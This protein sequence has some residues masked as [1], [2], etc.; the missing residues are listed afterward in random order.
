MSTLSWNC[1]GLG[2]P[3]A[4]EFL[5]DICFQKKPKFLFLCETLCTKELVDRVRVRLGFEGAFSVDVNGRKGGLSMFWRLNDE[6]KMLG[7]S[8][9]HIDLEVSIQDFNNIASNDEKK[10]VR[11]YPSALISGFQSARDDCHL[12]DLELRG[13]PFTWE[14]GKG[15]DHCIEIRLDKAN[16]THDWLDIFNHSTLTNIGYTCSDHAPIFLQP[17]TISQAAPFHCFRYKNVWSCEPICSQLVEDCWA[18]SQGIPISNNYFEL[19][20]QQEIYWKQRSK[21]FWLHYGDKNTKYFHAS[22][23]ARKRNNQIRQPQNSDGVWTDWEDG[24][25]QVIVNYFINLYTTSCSTNALVISE[26]NCTVSGSQNE[27]LL[28]P[29]SCEEVKLALFQIHPDKAPGPDGSFPKELNETNLVLIPK[30]KNVAT[31]GDLRPIA[32]CNVIYKLISK[33]LANRM[34]SIIDL[35]ISDTQSAFIPGRLISDNI[36]VAFEVMHYLKRKTKGK[37]GYMALKLD[38]SKDYDRVEWSYIHAVMLQMGFDEQWVK[39]IMFCVSSVSYSVMRD[40]HGMGPI[41]PSRGIRQGDPLSTYL[42]IICADGFSALI[43]KF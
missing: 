27:E 33:V 14:H 26:I 5:E 43:K 4:I 28:K 41:L 40:G 19:L 29:V 1:R 35:I 36:M 39:L 25:D 11:P 8:Q 24:L 32:L 31:M 16:V 10:G 21:Q 18:N 9:H 22:A 6:A 23:S 30:K 20:A 37:K 15:A 12:I 38:M 13:Y 3:R 42:F 2:N 7:F 17:E 34:R